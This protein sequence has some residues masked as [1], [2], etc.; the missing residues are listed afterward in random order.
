MT[1]VG[2]IRAR[3]YAAPIERRSREL[4]PSRTETERRATQLDLLNR[5]WSRILRD[6]P[7][8]E[9]LARER[10]LPEAFSSL[11]EFEGCVPATQRA[12]VQ[13][14]LGERTS[15]GRS[16]EWFR[17]TGGSTA[18]PVQIPAWRSETE[19]TRADFW[20]A[21]GWYGIDPAS[22]L[23]LLWGHSHLLGTGW[24]GWLKARRLEISDRLL[25]YHR[26][27]A[28][29]LRPE[30]MQR[31]ARTLLRFRPDYLLGYSTALDLFVR[32]NEG[33]RSELRRC[34]LRLVVATGEAFPAEDSAERLRDLF[35]CPVAMEYG[36]VETGLIAHTRPEG[37]FGV[38][39][40]SHLVEGEGQGPR[41]R[42]LVTSLY[43]RAFPLVRY[44]IGD[45]VDVPSPDTDGT[46]LVAFPRLVG[47]CNDYAEL[48]DGTLVHSEAFSHAVR[49][50]GAVRGYQIVQSGADLRLRYT[51]GRTLETADEAGIRER[52]RR[53][54]PALGAIAF[55]RVDA[56]DQTVAG[57][58]RMVVR[59]DG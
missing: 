29:D 8:Y 5:E 7:Y 38:F 11:E 40:R 55:E 22:R 46:S 25:G 10:G 56:L 28:Y 27:S 36:A 4:D 57:K 34:G 19:A 42:L 14:Q 30:A 23:F 15:R 58:T 48:S 24:R 31:A 49:P 18:A 17:I 43:P 53:V 39:W 32:A 13:E 41:R 12:D 33:H 21:R 37:G 20:V 9:R 35:D 2:G 45:E 16:A 51:A 1:L 3:L 26:F 47:R 59:A 52:L 44:Q 6:V 50:C 54:H